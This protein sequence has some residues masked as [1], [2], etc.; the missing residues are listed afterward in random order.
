MLI[1]TISKAEY[2]GST[3]IITVHISI[4]TSAVSTISSSTTLSSIILTIAINELNRFGYLLTTT[5]TST[6]SNSIIH[7]MTITITTT[8]VDYKS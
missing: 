1:T 2:E 5:T 8:S 4:T 3:L 7:F 6:T